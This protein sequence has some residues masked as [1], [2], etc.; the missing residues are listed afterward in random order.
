MIKADDDRFVVGNDFPRY[1]FGFNYSVEVKGFFMSMMWQGVGK[2]SRW[3]RGESVEA[4]H[5]NNEG[6][7]LDFHI[8]RWTPTNPDATYPRLTMGSES[9]NNAAKSDFW[10]MDAKY[11]RLKNI[12]FGYDFPKTLIG[13]IGIRGL[14]VYLSGQNLLTFDKMK[15]G[16]DPEYNADGSG[17]AYPVAKVY[18]FGL[19][20][21]F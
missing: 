10:I 15:G 8:D 13:K 14:R 7:V 17:R 11:L 19:N 18:S 3:M 12:Q 5:N 20:V 6:P 9:A 4:F 2:R 1:T 16:W 21:K